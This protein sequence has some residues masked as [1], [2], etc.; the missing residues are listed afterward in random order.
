LQR[1]AWRRLIVVWEEIRAL[2]ADKESQRSG[3]LWLEQENGLRFLSWRGIEEVHAPYCNLPTLIA[4]A[5][6][7]PRQVRKL[8]HP[9]VQLVLEVSAKASPHVCVQQI[10]HAPTTSVK[11]DKDCHLLDLWRYIMQEW[12]LVGRKDTLVICQKKVD[13]WLHKR[14]LPPNVA[15]RH[16]YDIAGLDLFGKTALGILA[17]APRPGPRKIEEIAGA[18]SGEW[19]EP[20]PAG[21]NGFAWYVQPSRG[22]RVL[23]QEI[24][25]HTL[26]DYH[27]EP[28]SEAVRWTY[29]D[30][31]LINALGRLRAINRT[32][33]F[34][35]QIRLLFDTCLPVSVNKVT[36]W[37]EP[38]RLV[39]ELAFNGLVAE[40]VD[41][42]RK[43]YP[44]RYKTRKA[45]RWALQNGV[46]VPPGFQTLEFQTVDA[47]R[48]KGRARVVHYDPTI[49]PDVVA[50]LKRR[51]GARVMA[52]GQSGP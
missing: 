13:V 5:V 17:G 36:R 24:G 44:E 32:A 27:P 51:L 15:V 10:L 12:T 20:I 26:G 43:L 11:L 31:E 49:V 22:I 46:L 45:A 33:E 34:P 40:D 39:E 21:M 48:H 9:N 2:L 30:A 28:M 14:G 35:C 41:T 6:L 19:Q 7:P 4:D 37:Q 1:C 42:L 52:C 18:L 47:S 8:L 38:S 3:R 16:Y 25:F 23:D 50:E 29:T